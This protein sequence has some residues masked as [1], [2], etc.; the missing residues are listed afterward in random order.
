ML[1]IPRCADTGLMPPSQSQAPGAAG[2]RYVTDDMPGIRRQKRGTGFTYIDP[3]GKVIREPAMLHRFRALVIP[4]AW[5]SVWICPLAEGHLQ[6][7]A[8]DAR[9]RK[10]YRYHPSF[11]QSR[12]QS[13]FER[14]FELKDV[15]WK[16]RTR[17]ED[18][19]ALEGLPRAKV[20]A[21]VVW[22]LERTLIRVGSEQLAR[23]NRSYGLTTMRHR[24]VEIEGTE[25]RFEFRGKSGVAHTVA[26]HDRR[27]AHIIQHCQE[28]PGQELFQYLDDD[29]RRQVVD[30]GDVNEYLREV[31]GRDITA[32][33]FRTWAG[34]ML[35]AEKL[36][37][38]GV[39]PTKRQAEKNVVAAI[40]AASAKLGNTRTVCRNF[41]VHPALIDAYLDGSVLPPLPP[42]VWRKR[43]TRSARNATLR[44]HEREVLDFLKARLGMSGKSPQPGAMDPVLV[45]G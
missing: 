12:D 7:T 8:R 44:R 27:I 34:T 33:D 23:L 10:V 18:D 13:K 3:D 2:L 25:I 22:L 4:P 31:T 9:G 5:T 20:M 42:R 35:A 28:L 32:K 6:V 29:G 37:E 11:R 17:V 19:I 1:R 45:P 41:Y 43:S 36:R 21:T 16:I 39:A 15:L 30:A 24:H 38:M 40:D 14:M 26:V